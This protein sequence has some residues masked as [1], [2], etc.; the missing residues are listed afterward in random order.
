MS[1]LQQLHRPFDVSECTAPK[2]R[3][4]RRVG[5]ARQALGFDARFDSAYLSYCDVVDAVR[6]PAHRLDEIFESLPEMRIA[7]DSSGAQQ[8]LCLPWCRPARVVMLVR[9][10][11]ARQWALLAFGPEVGINPQRR[12]R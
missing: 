10:E 1:H 12:V 6:R 11:A 2:F 5:T 8:G 7:R 4:R 3:V 9:R